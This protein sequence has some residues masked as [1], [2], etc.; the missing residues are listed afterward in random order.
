M[1]NKCCSKVVE[2]WHITVSINNGTPKSSILIG[3]SIINHPFSGT[4]IFGNT[5][6]NFGSFTLADM[7]SNSWRTKNERL[8]LWRKFL[9]EFSVP[10]FGAT[11]NT[12]HGIFS[13]RSL[14]SNPIAKTLVVLPIANVQR[15]TSSLSKRTIKS[16]HFQKWANNQKPPPKKKEHLQN[17]KQNTWVFPKIMV[18]Q[19]GW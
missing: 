8:G 17:K 13:G 9:F 7:I 4:T 14:C 16:L 19:N 10:S 11:R 5:H 6:I 3:C 2:K 15:F 1:T 12:T 18:P